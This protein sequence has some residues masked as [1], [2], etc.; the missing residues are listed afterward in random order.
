MIQKTYHDGNPEDRNAIED[1]WS[2]L[3][4]QPQDAWLLWARNANWDNAELIFEDMAAD[5]ECDLAIISWLFWLGSP[6]FYVD[7]PDQFTPGTLIHT[8]VTN[9]ERG[10]YRRSELFYDRFEVIHYAHEYLAT[11]RETPPANVAFRL[12]RALC[13]PFD[14]RKANLPARYDAATEADLDEIFQT[15]DGGLPRSE[16]DHWQQ[17]VEGGNVAIKDQLSLPQVPFDPLTA[18][19]RLDDAAYVE[20]IFAT[21]SDYETARAA[22]YRGRRA[23]MAAPARFRW[24][25]FN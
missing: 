22:L 11:V 15:I 21:A 5:P 3:R 8:I 24:W 17:Q 7:K 6:A 14:G 16:A 10:F 12:P 19:A 13:G 20:A 4:H 1:F 23:R 2:W 9:T 25:P 18:Y